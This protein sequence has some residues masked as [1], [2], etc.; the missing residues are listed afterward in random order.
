METNNLNY[1]IIQQYLEGKLSEKEMHDLERRA[2]EDPFLAEAIEGY[3]ASPLT[4][5][6]HLSLLQK[7]LEERVA[8]QADDKNRFYFTWQRLSVAAAAGLLFVS[9]GILFWMK[10]DKAENQLANRQKQV[11]VKLTPVDS[12]QAEE[13]DRPLENNITMLEDDTPDHTAAA[14]H[15]KGNKDLY[16]V[17]PDQPASSI[18][19]GD[20]LAYSQNIDELA[21]APVNTADNEAALRRSTQVR[22]AGNSQT[23]TPEPRI[24][25]VSPIKKS[26]L[27][28]LSGRVV[29]KSD[30]SPVKGVA[31][32]LNGSSKT[33]VTNELGEFSLADS[34]GGTVRLTSP[35]YVVKEVQITSGEHQ[36]IEMQKLNQPLSEVPAPVDGNTEAIAAPMP[37]IGWDEYNA[38]L[39]DRS[40]IKNTTKITG[41]V[42]VSM[43]VNAN[44]QLTNLRVIKG[45]NK[46]L[47]SEAVRL[48]KEGPTWK[49]ASSLKPAT[50]KVT[51]SFRR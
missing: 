19:Q 42:I 48:I 23:E 9:A 37:A 2:L 50:V 27:N 10:G 1:T 20:S 46:A 32:T 7:Q 31:V 45:I 6:R 21:A 40:R 41:D 11:E 38:Y 17:E 26:A 15:S 24:T 5:G 8:Q 16:I 43:I 30:G 18:K 28:A 47:N 3:A 51:V 13:D 36:V 44:G 12:L 14:G 49:P 33:V 29:D 25:V 34:L 4:A 35:D 39:R 22:V